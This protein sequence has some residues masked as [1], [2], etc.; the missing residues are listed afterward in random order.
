MAAVPMLIDGCNPSNWDEP[1]VFDNLAAGG[2]TACNA[3]VAFWEGF[4]ETVDTFARWLRRF[5]VMEDRL[6][7]VRSVADIE[8]AHATGRIGIILGWQNLS[9]IEGDLARLEVFQALGLRVA[10]LTYNIR[11]LVGNGCF[12]RR[13][14][15]LSLFGLEAVRAL[16]ELGIL[17]DLSHV[18][19]ERAREAIEASAAPVAFTHANLR[20]FFDVPRNKP[21]D[22][23]RAVADRG[24]VI[25]ANAFP[26]FLPGGYDATLDDFLDAIESLVE[27]VGVD[28]VGIAT[29]FCEG[30]DLDYWRWL[31]ALHGTFQRGIPPVPR[32][33]P[34]VAGLDTSADLPVVVQALAAR[35]WSADD[36]DKVAGANW[37]R[38]FSAEWHR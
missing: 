1:T 13:D 14:D 34:S 20:S 12:E 33:D 8:L 29:D 36:I 21:T 37:L 28:H 27:V 16:N 17:I 4:E 2:V 30:R 7:P 11:N 18:G 26:Q 22:L 10:Q 24:G 23:V 35:G 6:V 9:P 3:T 38:L 5:R 31:R 32:P 15:G 19:D 25:G